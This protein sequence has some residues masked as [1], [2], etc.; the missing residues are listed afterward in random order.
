MVV[1]FLL[2]CNCGMPFFVMHFILLPS[3]LDP[4]TSFSHYA[5]F[6]PSYFHTLLCFAALVHT[7]LLS[8]AVSFCL[9]SICMGVSEIASKVQWLQE[10]K[11]L[12]SSK[13]STPFFLKSKNNKHEAL[14]CIIFP[15]AISHCWSLLELKHPSLL[16]SV[17]PLACRR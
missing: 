2:C 5:V 8:L 1:S 11:N 7:I 12:A 3:P 17:H 6:S 16:V 13:K 14:L 10:D 4:C 9:L 15:S